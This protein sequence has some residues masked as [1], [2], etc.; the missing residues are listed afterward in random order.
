M[1][2]ID[3]NGNFEYSSTIEVNVN[4][5]NMVYSLANNFPNPSNPTTLI[6]YTLAFDSNVKLT[7][8]NSLGQ[9][10]KELI[11]SIQPGGMHEV[12]FDG[13]N[14]SSGTYFYS[15]HAAS[16]DGSQNFTNTKKMILLK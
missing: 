4:Y 7:V 10:V 11:S 8:Y 14:L 6:R 15:L 9:T 13:S 16:L 3:N 12:N 1:K 2:Q 5:I